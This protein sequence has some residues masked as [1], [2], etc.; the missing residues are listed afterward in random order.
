MEKDVNLWWRIWIIA[1]LFPSF[2]FAQQ[3]IEAPSYKAF[4]TPNGQ[5]DAY[6]RISA[7]PDTIYFRKDRFGGFSFE[8]VNL[9]QVS[10]SPSTVVFQGI[11]DSIR[12]QLSYSDNHDCLSIVA[13]IENLSSQV[14]IPKEGVKLY[15]GINTY[16]D[17]YPQW[18]DTYFP[19][20]LRCERTHFTSYFMTP[21]KGILAMASPDPIASWSHEY[22]GKKDTLRG[23]EIMY[24][25]HRIY[26]SSLYLLHALPLPPRHPQDLYYLNPGEIKRVRL[27]L[28]SVSTLE[29]VPEFFFQLTEAPNLSAELYTLPQGEKFSGNIFIQNIQRIEIRTPRDEVDTLSIHPIAPNRYQWSYLPYSG[30][31]E[32][33]VTALDTNGKMSEMKLYVRP[34]FEFY[35]RS[36]RKEAL[37]SKPTTTHHAECFYPLYTY[38]LAKKY[39]PDTHEDTRAEAVFDSIFT[40]L[41]EKKTGEMRNGKYRIQDAATM[42]GI[43]SDRYQITGNEQDLMHAASL[44]DYLIKCQGKDGGYYNPAH[45]VHYTSVIYIAKSI[46][47]VMNE[48]KKLAATSDKWRKIYERHK[49]SVIKAMDDLAQ[50]GDNVE[51]E[52][53]MTFEDG[54]I[55]CSVS[56]LSLAA[57]KTNDEKRRKLYTEQAITLNNKHLCLT[58]SLIP[59]SRMNGATLRFWEYQYTVNL[60]Q[61]GLN[62]PCGWSAWKYYGSWYLYLLTGKPRYMKEVINGLGSCM[63]LLDYHTGELRFSFLPD[64]SIK[65]YQF[66]EIPIGSRQP[67]LNKVV[68]GEQ[69]IPQ[70]SNW[71]F[72]APYAWRKSKFGIDNFVHEIFKCMC[73]IFMENAYVIE[74]NPGMLK[75]INCHLKQEKGHVEVSYDSSR[76]KNLHV[77]TTNEYKLKINGEIHQSSGCKWIIGYPDELNPF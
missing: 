62:S 36:A 35:L 5:I 24:G 26:T 23:K 55:S 17:K 32:Y 48:E 74:V 13:S 2:I 16:M 3:I 12:Y 21:H 73:E 51:T 60:M 71:H 56:Q 20:M 59:D 53:Q 44:V 45:H 8:N 7:K 31:G 47:E 67:R 33:T 75:G 70:I 10:Q 22:E 39:V 37:R 28:K 15:C 69:Y 14:F 41:Y 6:V 27:Y 64:P 34:D 65:G 63:Q 58:Q 1:S 38:F 25:E 52:G 76:I 30:I 19:T 11:K 50:R 77:N 61:N 72:A 42:A 9:T 54:M 57:L 66:M 4:I 43:L 49:T 46:M 18:N 68:L 40:T 29:K